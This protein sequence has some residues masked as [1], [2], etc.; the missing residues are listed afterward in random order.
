MPSLGD[1]KRRIGS[2]KNT[3]QITNAMNLVSASKL[4]KAKS[5]VAKTTPYF[6]EMRNVAASVVKNSK[7][8]NHPFLI[9]KDG[10]K[11]LIITITSD[12]GLCGGYNANI[13]KEVFN[14]ISDKEESLYVIGNKGYDY[15]NRRKKNIVGRLNGVSE[16]PTYE[17]ARKLGEFAVEGY[18]NGDFDEVYVAYTEFKSTITHI[19][20]IIKLLPVDTNEFASDE[21]D[22]AET[23]MSLMKYDPSEEEVLTYIVPK[24]INT[25]I[26][27]ALV[28][29]STCEQAARMTAMDAATEN[30]N[31]V[32]GSLTLVYNRARQSA[33][34]QEITEIVSGANALE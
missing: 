19:P 6:N 31:E 2:V 7:G 13:S 27:G 22:T 20:S 21:D 8:I 29:S 12:R 24:Y 26:Y 23:N 1:V 17:D 10:K 28:A 15:F 18:T 4:Q 3:K 32:I 16:N 11:V 34:T 33:I 9:E 25:V 14:F 5:T 30:A